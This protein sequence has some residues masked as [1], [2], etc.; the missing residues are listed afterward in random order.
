MDGRLKIRPQTIK[1]LKENTT[2]EKYLTLVLAI[3]I[4]F[5]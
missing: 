3:I 4:V 5:E 1:L 2:G